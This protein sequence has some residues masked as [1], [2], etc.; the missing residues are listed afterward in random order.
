MQLFSNLY[1]SRT[2]YFCPKKKKNRTLNSLLR[3][4][5]QQYMGLTRKNDV[6]V[7]DVE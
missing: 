1:Y 2:L 3:V 7:S 6:C 5:H 4:P